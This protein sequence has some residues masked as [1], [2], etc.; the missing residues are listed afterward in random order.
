MTLR[1]MAVRGCAMKNLDAK[2]MLENGVT[3]AHGDAT[4]KLTLQQYEKLTLGGR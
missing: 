1:K 2:Q 3:S 4:L